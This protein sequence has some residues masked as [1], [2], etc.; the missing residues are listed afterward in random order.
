MATVI[1]KIKRVIEIKFIS[2]FR[3]SARNYIKIY[4]M[5]IDMIHNQNIIFFIS[6][7]FFSIT[8]NLSYI[9]LLV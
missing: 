2:I 8:I 1:T 9:S 6:P 5:F 7:I 3:M 4:T